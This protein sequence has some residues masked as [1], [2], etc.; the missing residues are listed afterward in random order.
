MQNGCKILILTAGYGDGHW[1]VSRV[2]RDKFHRR[3][4]SVKI[5]DLFR[6]SHPAI[7]AVTRFLYIRSMVLASYG[8]DY[9]GWSYYLTRNM[10]HDGL[11]AH[12]INRF[13]Q[14][15]LTQVIRRERPGAILSTF[16]FG[17]IADLL[18]KLQF[19]IPVF[20][21]I[22][23]FALHNRWLFSGADRYYV[24]TD[25]LK[26]E[27]MRRGIPEKRIMVSGI[28][29]RE[30]FY[31]TTGLRRDHRSVLLMAGAYGVLRDLKR[32]TERL[33]ALPDVRIHV[34]C[35]KN[36]KL[37]RELEASFAKESRLRIW[38]FVERIDERMRQASCIITKAGGITLSEAVQ[39]CVPIL[40]FKPFPGQEKEN[41]LYFSGQGAALVSQTTEELAEQT[42]KMLYCPNTRKNMVERLR[43]LQKGR[44]SDM[45]V[46]DMIETGVQFGN[47]AN[48]A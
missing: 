31:D 33:L 17:G 23:D 8:M 10:P 44:A 12:W 28:P 11:F 34:V 6:E 25:D 45:I 32:I 39:T 36:E 20:T 48:N 26:L 30:P 38:G 9:Y 21:V 27:M 15:T 41:A 42:Q 40:I 3:G 2:L 5:V 46:H 19:N 1:Q 7:D 29:V 14:R 16:P 4:F 22:T 18:R 43:A 37:K 13:G 24:A 47:A 35:G